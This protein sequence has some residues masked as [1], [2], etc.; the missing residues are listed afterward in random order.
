MQACGDAPP[1]HDAGDGVHRKRVPAADRGQHRHGNQEP[2]QPVHRTAQIRKR[3]RRHGDRDR[4]LRD[5]ITGIHSGKLA[6]RRPPGRRAEQDAEQDAY[7]PGQHGGHCGPPDRGQARHQQPHDDQ[8]H[9][10]P[11]RA[12]PE[13]CGDQPA[14]RRGRRVH[15]MHDA[16]LGRRVGLHDRDGH[17]HDHDR[18]PQPECIR[19]PPASGAAAPRSQHCRAQPLRQP[20][21]RSRNSLAAHC[22]RISEENASARPRCRA[23]CLAGG[24]ARRDRWPGC[25]APLNNECPLAFR[26]QVCSAPGAR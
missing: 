13:D 23:A 4:E 3:G 9:A 21:A 6:D 11:G 15:G 25:R 17:C 10:D 12:E 1:Q 7:A 8:Q 24:L 2:H 26:L 14:D 20:M 18:E 16:Q 5:R 22:G 19:R